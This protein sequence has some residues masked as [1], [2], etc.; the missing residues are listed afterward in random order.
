MAEARAWATGL[1]TPCVVSLSSWVS[2]TMLKVW[3][4]QHSEHVPM[5]PML[6]L[7][8]AGAD[9]VIGHTH[10][11]PF[12][13]QKTGF[14]HT[15]TISSKYSNYAQHLTVPV[16]ILLAT[17]IL[18]PPVATCC[19]V[20]LP[21]PLPTPPPTPPPQQH[22]FRTADPPAREQSTASIDVYH[23]PMSATT[24]HLCLVGH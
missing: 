12:I 6:R 8:T 7:D 13:C 4:A 15:L 10:P 22:W 14:S 19:S 17:L 1:S 21:H 3:C 18:G 11:V 5:D 20:C 2:S 24:G 9:R 23:V 16:G